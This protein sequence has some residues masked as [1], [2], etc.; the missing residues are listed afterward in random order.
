MKLDKYN[1]DDMF[2]GWFIGNF[3]PSLFKTNEVED[4]LGN[5][6]LDLQNSFIRTPIDPNLTFNDDPLRI[7]RVIRFAVRF[8]FFITECIEK[9]AKNPEIKVQLKFKNLF[10]YRI[11]LLKIQFA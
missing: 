4:F 8:Q 1:L 2:K 3:N 9:A 5:G 11:L 7:L 6:I 10:F